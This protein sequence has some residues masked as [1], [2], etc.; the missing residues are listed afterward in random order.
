MTPNPLDKKAVFILLRERKGGMEGGRVLS[1]T[2]WKHLVKGEG[3][4]RL[5]VRPLLASLS[6]FTLSVYRLMY[7]LLF[8]LRVQ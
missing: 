1:Y 3:C 7:R 8:E 2:R 5:E 6:T 4:V